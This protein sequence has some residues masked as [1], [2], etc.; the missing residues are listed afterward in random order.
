M[1]K[2][3]GSNPGLLPS[4]GFHTNGLRRTLAAEDLMALRSDRHLATLCSATALPIRG[5]LVDKAPGARLLIMARALRSDAH[6]RSRI[7]GRNRI[8]QS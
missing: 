4:N 8:N 1:L 7:Y 2:V 5:R 6:L 3:E